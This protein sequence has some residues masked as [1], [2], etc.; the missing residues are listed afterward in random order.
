MMPEGTQHFSI[1]TAP[2]STVQG[3][4]DWDNVSSHQDLQPLADNTFGIEGRSPPRQEF[5][6]SNWGSMSSHQD[7]QSWADNAFDIEGRS[8][9]SA[10]VSAT[11]MSEAWDCV[12][13]NHDL[14]PSTADVF[15]GRPAQPSA[16]E[17][18]HTLWEMAGHGRYTQAQ[19]GGE[20]CDPAEPPPPSQPTA[21]KIKSAPPSLA[22]VVDVARRTAPA[23]DWAQSDTGEYVRRQLPYSDDFVQ[24]PRQTSAAMHRM[25]TADGLRSQPSAADEEHTEE[26]YDDLDGAKLVSE[27]GEPAVG[28]RETMSAQHAAIG[29]LRATHLRQ[30]KALI[31]NAPDSEI[32]RF[33]EQYG[34]P[35]TEPPAARDPQLIYWAPAPPRVSA[36]P[37]IP[38][39]PLAA[40]AALDET[41][42][43][44]GWQ[45]DC[46]VV[47]AARCFFSFSPPPRRSTTDRRHIDIYSRLIV[48]RPQIGARSTPI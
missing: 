13:Y 10:A 26:I 29:A 32:Y 15:Q 7:L 20:A 40:I 19:A 17:N 24:G 6:G 8:P 22:S 12:S 1:A 48:D 23:T 25:S 4:S 35:A 31:Q 27:P 36:A 47:T 44:F 33:Y 43:A 9:P 39:P 41:Q 14:Q 38:R 42:S 30:M 28:G 18:A 5:G 46:T 11:P 2:S 45:S 21:A 16:V 34:Q 37:P 3:T